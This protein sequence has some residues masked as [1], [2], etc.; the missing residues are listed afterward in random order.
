MSWI[1]FERVSDKEGYKHF[2]DTLHYQECIAFLGLA[3]RG[4]PHPLHSLVHFSRDTRPCRDFYNLKICAS[5]RTLH[6][7]KP[8]IESWILNW[9]CHSLPVYKNAKREIRQAFSLKE[10]VWHIENIPRILF[11]VAIKVRAII[12]NWLLSAPPTDLR[13]EPWHLTHSEIKW[14]AISFR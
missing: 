5:F 4:I 3:R 14:I 2:T 10:E 12:F 13:N 6:D 1:S 9:Q 8:I 7:S 11:L